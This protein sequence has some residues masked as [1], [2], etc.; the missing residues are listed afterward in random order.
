M[1]NVAD[2]IKE[3][4]NR[5]TIKMDSVERIIVKCD[6]VDA[7]DTETE[8]TKA[9]FDIRCVRNPRRGENRVT[10]TAERIIS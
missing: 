2:L 5:P 9:G 8:L 1:E 10:L 6:L 3:N 7:I 4:C